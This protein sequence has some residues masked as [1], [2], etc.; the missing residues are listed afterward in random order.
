MAAEVVSQADPLLPEGARAGGTSQD[1]GAWVCRSADCPGLSGS[2]RPALSELHRV[3]DLRTIIQQ[4]EGQEES[5]H[6]NISQ[7]PPGASRPLRL[8]Y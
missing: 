2:Q 6:P 4:E 7:G 8:P 5:Y 1:L 3:E